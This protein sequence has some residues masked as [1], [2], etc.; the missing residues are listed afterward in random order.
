MN[1]KKIIVSKC[2]LLLFYATTMNHFS[3]GLWFELKSGFCRTTGNDQI[4]G[5]TKTL[6]STSQ[7]QTCTKKKKKKVTG[8]VWW[9]AASLIHC[10]FLNPSKTIISERSACQIDEIHWKLQ[11]LQSALVNRKGP[12]LLHD[13]AWLHVTQPM[14]QKLNELGNE[15]LPYLSY[16]PDLSPTKYHFFKYLNNH[17]QGKHFQNQEEAENAFQEFIESWSMIFMLPE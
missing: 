12:I 3:N 17:L 4:S 1:I 10:S 5:W 15:V 13:N 11:C 14:L 9:S 2:H 6:Q 7:S 8:T 16:S